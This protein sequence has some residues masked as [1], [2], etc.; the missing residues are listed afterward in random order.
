MWQAQQ[1]LGPF[2]VAVPPTRR[3]AV[4]R[5][6]KDIKGT[7]DRLAGTPVQFRQPA[8][9]PVFLPRTP[10]RE[11]QDI[12]TRRIDGSDLL[13]HVFLGHATMPAAD[14]PDARQSLFELCTS[15]DI[16]SRL[17]PEQKNLVALVHALLAVPRRL[18]QRLSLMFFITTLCVVM[19]K[20]EAAA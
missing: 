8:C 20:A 1:T 7:A 11:E 4:Y 12:C 6:R 17:R 13:R 10:Q 2:D 18:P 16:G 19:R 3:G 14:D 5:T 9:H 15:A